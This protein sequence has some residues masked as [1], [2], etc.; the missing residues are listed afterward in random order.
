[1]A[2]LAL[3]LI[4]IVSATLCFVL[5]RYMI[6]PYR[7]T[8]E[9]RY[10]GLPLGFGFLGVSY[11][12]MGFALYFESFIFVDEIKWLQLFTQAYAFAFFAATYYF[13]KKP[14]KN[15]RLWW[16]ITY[17]GLLFAAIVSYLVVFEPPMF[18]L[19]SYKTVDEYFRLFNII[20]LA[21]VSI[22]ILRSHASKPDPKTIWII[23]SYALLGFGQYSSLIWSLDSSFTAYVGAHLLRLSGLL[24]FLLWSA[25]LS[26]VRVKHT[27]KERLELRKLTR[28]DR[29]KIYGDL[30]FVLQSESK[31]G[32]IVLTRV[33]QKINVPYDRLKPYIA[34]LKELGL[35]EDVTTLK[36]TEKGKLF[37]R[38]YETVL[39]SM[40]RMGLAHR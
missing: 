13:S 7:A 1:M 12:F 32:K 3:I 30:L 21:Y 19:P 23:L 10:I 27:Q 9:G 15:T 8:R 14:A 38:E 22:H 28:R 36:L 35:I 33:Q 40:K 20:C 18:E 34:E 16:N 5:L 24:I 37:L 17:A 25:K 4:E 2:N 29:M 39:D 26:T 6:K 31:T 11:I